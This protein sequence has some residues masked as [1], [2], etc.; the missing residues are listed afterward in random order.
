VQM[1][2]SCKGVDKSRDKLQQQL[3]L[4]FL[5]EAK[6]FNDEKQ[7][8]TRTIS[9]EQVMCSEE[10]R[11]EYAKNYLF[12]VLLVNVVYN[13]Y[14]KNYILQLLEQLL[15]SNGRRKADEVRRDREY[16]CSTSFFSR[17]IA[18]TLQK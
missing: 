6:A 7:V 1:C 4:S 8:K 14:F 17:L 5:P 15:K 18:A 10:R 12:L 13:A 3:T 16:H 11:Y 2:A 9:H